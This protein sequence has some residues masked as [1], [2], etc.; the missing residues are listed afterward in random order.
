MTKEIYIEAV[1]AIE[2]QMRK[3]MNFAKKLA[4]AFPSAFYANLMPD[5]ELLYNALFKVLETETGDIEKD[6]AN[7]SWLTWFC[8]E[9]DFGRKSKE[10]VATDKN[11]NRL[12]FETAGDLYDFLKEKYR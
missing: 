3:D 10:M 12:S 9:T 8:Y 5:N 6:G 7:Y 2:G 1:N 11:G 4:E